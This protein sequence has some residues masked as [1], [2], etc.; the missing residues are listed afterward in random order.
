MP[1]RRLLVLLVLLTGSLP[2]GCAEGPL[3]RTGRLSPLARDKWL[4]E[5]QIADTL[6]ERKRSMNSLVETA[7]AGSTESMNQAAGELHQIVRRD[8][9]LLLR[10]HAV[11]LLGDLNC[12]A[13]VAALRDAA[14]DPD[15]DVRIAAV[16]SWQ[17]F[18]GNVAV[19]ELQGII[20]ADTDTDVRMAATRSL[21]SFTG[22]N[23]VQ[24]LSFAL[25]DNDPALQVRATESL[26]R[27]TG[28]NIGPDVARW[29]DY[30]GRLVPSQLPSQTFP[31][32]RTADN[33]ESVFR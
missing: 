18:P 10:L 9:V 1:V 26:A 23:A 11:K 29:Q 32:T 24:A 30:V 17:K 3:W 27:V 13:S 31:E 33:S 25:T 22:T 5:E 16:K 20:Q 6:F 12:P 8:P 4:A 14:G 2:L 21:G 28:E 19:T 7:R 15:A